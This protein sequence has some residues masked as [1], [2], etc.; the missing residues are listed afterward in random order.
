[1]NTD[2]DKKLEK[3]FSVL[4]SEDAARAPSFSRVM[5]AAAREPEVQ[6]RFAFPWLQLAGGMAVLLAIMFSLENLT[7]TEPQ[8]APTVD[9]ESWIKLS[10]WSASTDS[11]LTASASSTAAWGNQISTTT[12]SW[13]EKTEISTSNQPNQNAL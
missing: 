1:M 13:I 10:A 12:D 9:T 6:P 8:P 3:L 2:D 4:K 5:R 11:L 7:F